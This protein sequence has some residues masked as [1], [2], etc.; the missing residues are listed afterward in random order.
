MELVEVA[1]LAGLAEL[2]ELVELVQ[3]AELLELADIEEIPELVEL[4][5]SQLASS[6]RAP[7][8][9]VACASCS[10]APQRRSVRRSQQP[11][12]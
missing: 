9:L 6:H 5:G 3:L 7:A 11:R 10:I 12:D 2:V 8:Q 1:K 4:V